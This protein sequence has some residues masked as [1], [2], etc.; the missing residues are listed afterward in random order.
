MGALARLGIF[1]GQE[2]PSYWER[3]VN[4]YLPLAQKPGFSN[5]DA[6]TIPFEFATCFT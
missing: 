5:P 3:L 4:F 2:C 1:D 6:G